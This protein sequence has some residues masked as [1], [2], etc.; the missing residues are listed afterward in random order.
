[1]NNKILLPELTEYLQKFFEAN[2][3]EIR[4]A[5][6]EYRPNNGY[7]NFYRSDELYQFMFDIYANIDEHLLDMRIPENHASPKSLVTFIKNFVDYLK[8]REELIKDIRSKHNS[9]MVNHIDEIRVKLID[10]FE[11]CLTFDEVKTII[12]EPAPKSDSEKESSYSFER[13]DITDPL[14][15]LKSY[16]L[17][18]L[19]ITNIMRLLRTK[20]IV[21]I[22]TSIISIIVASFILG[23]KFQRNEDVLEAIDNKQTIFL[24]KDSIDNYRK[25]VLIINDSLQLLKHKLKIEDSINKK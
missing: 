10:V 1:M 17:E 5:N 12:K 14:V 21:G 19:P 15:L 3:E 25:N 13:K 9:M 7:G 8:M 2:W 24:Q 16:D 20:Q 23:G 11:H 18:E 4:G 22:I 6:S